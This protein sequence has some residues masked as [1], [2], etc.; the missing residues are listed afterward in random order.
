MTRRRFRR[1]AKPVGKQFLE[2]NFSAMQPAELERQ[3]R[4]AF[5][6]MTSNTTRARIVKKNGVAFLQQLEKMH[7]AGVKIQ[8][9][10]QCANR[11]L[12]A[13]NEVSVG[14]PAS[15]RNSLQFSS[16]FVLKSLERLRATSNKKLTPS[17]RAKEEIRRLAELPA[18]RR[19]EIDL[20]K[21]INALSNIALREAVGLFLEGKS[22][23]DCTKPLT[24]A[25]SFL[26]SLD[27]SVLSPETKKLIAEK[28]RFLNSMCQHSS[29]RNS[30]ERNRVIRTLVVSSIEKANTLSSINRVDQRISYFLSRKWLNPETAELLHSEVQQKRKAISEKMMSKHPKPKTFKFERFAGHVWLGQW[31]PLYKLKNFL[32]GLSEIKARRALTTFNPRPRIKQG[33]PLGAEA[34]KILSEAEKR[35][36][37]ENP[38]KKP[39]LA[40]LLEFMEQTGR[41]VS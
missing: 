7:K 11:Y 38:G 19:V 26:M 15:T 31:V 29:I 27:S 37:A 30:V 21:K 6:S 5:N 1:K 28:K 2:A 33:K 25:R 8:E 23:K 4:S 16:F 35:F 13:L 3:L 17:E 22:S 18:S 12:K 32:S 10:E 39:T 36:E 14:E 40:A 41:R 24:D 20:V 9:I 34:L